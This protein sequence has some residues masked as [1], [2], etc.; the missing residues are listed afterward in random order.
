[1][2]FFDLEAVDAETNTIRRLGDLCSG[3][4]A[5]LVVN[6]ASQCEGADVN[7]EQLEAIYQHLRP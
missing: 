5:T 2:K 4:T 7:F 3:K 6:V 1:M